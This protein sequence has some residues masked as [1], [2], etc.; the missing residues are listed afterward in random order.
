MLFITKSR[1]RSGLV[2]YAASSFRIG[3]CLL[4]ATGFGWLLLNSISVAVSGSTVKAASYNSLIKPVRLYVIPR[5]VRF[6]TI[7]YNV[8]SLPVAFAVVMLYKA[9][10]R[11]F[12][13]RPCRIR[14]AINLI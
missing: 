4:R 6:I 13:I 1:F 7:S 11:A 3:L 5:A 2:R 9:I 12:T 10:L 14:T 8:R